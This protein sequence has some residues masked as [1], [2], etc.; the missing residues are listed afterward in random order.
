MK[1]IILFAIT[2]SLGTIVFGQSEPEDILQYEMTTPWTDQVDPENVWNV[3]PRPQMKRTEWT[4]LNGLWE[5]AIRDTS[6]GKP[7]KFDGRILT[8]FAVE[9]TL[10]QVKKTVGE[11]NYLWYRTT[12]ETPRLK[13]GERRLLHFGAVDW[14]TVVFL[15]GKKFGAHPG[16]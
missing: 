1:K 15:N 7:Q 14:E 2:I 9:S 6:E 8:P 4:N 11:K 5:Y 3:Y 12:F 16:G 13:K 10:S